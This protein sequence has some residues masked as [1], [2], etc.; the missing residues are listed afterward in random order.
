MQEDSED[1]NCLHSLPLLRQ[2]YPQELWECCLSLLVSYRV[3]IL[4]DVFHEQDKLWVGGVP[5]DWSC[6]STSASGEESFFYIT[7]S[8]VCECNGTINGGEGSIVSEVRESLYKSPA[9]SYYRV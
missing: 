2:S 5:N 3:R 4:Q 9:C 8:Q 7:S 6:V 1:F